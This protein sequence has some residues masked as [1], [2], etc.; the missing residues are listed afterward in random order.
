MDLSQNK[1]NGF[2]PAT[3]KEWKIEVENRK[4][5]R[6]NNN[7]NIRHR[8]PSLDVDP[9]ESLL[10]KGLVKE[11]GKEDPH[12]SLLTRGWEEGKDDDGPAATTAGDG[13]AAT[14]GGGG[15]DDAGGAG[16][17]NGDGETSTTATTGGGGYLRGNNREH[18]II[19][20]VIESKEEGE[21][22][23]ESEEEGE[24]GNEESEEGEEGDKVWT[25]EEEDLHK[26]ED[27]LTFSSQK[28]LEEEH[29]QRYGGEAHGDDGPIGGL[30]EAN[31]EGT[32]QKAA[33]VEEREEEDIGTVSEEVTHEKEVLKPIGGGEEHM[34]ETFETYGQ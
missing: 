25:R 22:G 15:D 5:E 20:P 12:A 11:G 21:E 17:S 6:K 7:Y 13:P 4:T 27:V 29:N 19:K 1:F 24:E 14:T 16:D 31:Q 18:S 23:E 9:L 33:T 3:F 28:D 26:E 8:N 32:H 30:E 10:E 34:G 2:M